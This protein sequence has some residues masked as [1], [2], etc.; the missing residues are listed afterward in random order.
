MACYLADVQR[1]YAAS[2]R[3]LVTASALALQAGREDEVSA[4]ALLLLSVQHLQRGDHATALSLLSFLHQRHLQPGSA[5]PLSVPLQA[6]ILSA[7]AIGYMR[8]ENRAEEAETAFTAAMSTRQQVQD[9]TAALHLLTCRDLLALNARLRPSASSLPSSLA[10]QSACEHIES[11]V[12]PSSSYAAAARQLSLALLQRPHNVSL[13]VAHFDSAISQLA[14]LHAASPDP[15]LA[16]SLI[17]L[18]YTLSTPSLS[19]SPP[20]PPLPVLERF[21]SVLS[22]SHPRGLGVYTLPCLQVASAMLAGG[23]LWVQGMDAVRQGYE[24][25]RGEGADDEVWRRL[26]S[27][28]FTQ[29]E[30]EKAEERRREEERER[31]RKRIEA[32]QLQK[33]ADTK[34]TEL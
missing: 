26:Y 29:A 27:W 3:F 23:G 25:V 1:D 16:L 22:S 20:S 7:L 12:F 24:A 8:A 9:R 32:E 2:G 19:P 28:M 33:D 31:E 14:Q 5:Q 34:Q 6:D 15:R 17:H 4:A 13:A 10:A 18:V 30:R 11:S 21:F